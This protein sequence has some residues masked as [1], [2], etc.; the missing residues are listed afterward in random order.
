MHTGMLASWSGLIVLYELITFDPTD[1]AY[2]PCWRQGSYV[3]P[4]ISRIGAI[5]SLYSWSLGIK[6]NYSIWTYETIALSHLDLS[7]ALILA[8]FWHWAYSDLNVFA[9]R[10][11]RLLVLDLNKI[12]G[13]HFILASVLCFGFGYHHL[14]GFIGPGM[15]TS[16]S[17]GLEGCIRFVKP[18]YSLISTSPKWYALIPSHHIASGFSGIL[19]ALWHIQAVPGPLLYKSN[20]MANIESVLSS[21]ISSVFFTAFIESSVIW[22]GS[23]SAALELFGPNRYHWDNGYFSQD[24][25]GR[26]SSVNSMLLNKAWEQMPDKLVLYD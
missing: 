15:W 1:P 14:S 7:V 18:I 4:F 17:K 10:S 9:H 8:S 12:L 3:I 22:Y 6:L 19:I 13:I 2:N 24:I 11:T 16:D 20:V 23:V 21:S 26:V 25:E 5:S